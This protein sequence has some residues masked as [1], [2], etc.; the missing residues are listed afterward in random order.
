M[1]EIIRVRVQYASRQQYCK[2]HKRPLPFTFIGTKSER[3]IKSGHVS[4]CLTIL[5][6]T[7]KVLVSNLSPYIGLPNII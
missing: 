3:N 1:K 2:T 5:F 7:E 6:L 4:A